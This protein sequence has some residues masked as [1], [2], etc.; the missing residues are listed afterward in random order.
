M[1]ETEHENP[2]TLAD[3]LRHRIA[4][5]EGELAVMRERISLQDAAD[6]HHRAELE[7]VRLEAAS[8]RV[9]LGVAQTRVEEWRRLV[10]E[11]RDRVSA[12]EMRCERAE[13]ERATLVAKLERNGPKGFRRKTN[14]S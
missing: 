14:D 3:G 4:R 7:A 9:A 8:S 11:A 12:A 1:S 6:E 13:A 10:A 5:L 2:E